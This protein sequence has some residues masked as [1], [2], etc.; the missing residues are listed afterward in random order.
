VTRLFVAVRPPDTVRRRL[1]EL[2]RDE[3][4]GVRWVPPAQWH[5]TLRFVGDAP[6]EQVVERLAAVDL[7]S[8]TARLGPVVSRLGRDA[9][10]IPVTGLD[11]LAG[12][13]R[14]ATEDI[15]RPPGPRPFNGH[16]TLARLRQR[17]ACGVA[18]T[19]FVDEF[20]VAE[21]EL[22]SS[23]LEPTGAVHQVVG[24]WPT[25]LAASPSS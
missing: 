22:V 10:V 3:Q 16:L 7:P 14:A 25:R 2:P 24:R 8:S 23:V 5:I 15:G 13:V 6:V 12:T 18:G 4:P 9:V 11:A 20:Q 19:R 17:V 1:L 21:I